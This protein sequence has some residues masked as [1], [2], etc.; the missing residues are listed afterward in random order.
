MNTIFTCYREWWKA[1][2]YFKRPVWHF[3]ITE[4]DRYWGTWFGI[5]PLAW[6][7][8]YDEARFE[9]APEIFIKVGKERFFVWKLQAP[10]KSFHY[11]YPDDDHY[12]EA[13]LTYLYN[14]FDRKDRKY[15]RDISKTYNE[16]VWSRLVYSDEDTKNKKYDNPVM[17]EVEYIDRAL[18]DYAKKELVKNGIKLHEN[19]LEQIMI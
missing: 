15:K 12:W 4:T 17:K 1:R 11:D 10:Y 6:K 16:Y 2:K 18:T 14:H 9:E 8:K 7:M 13:L 5:I 19:G 3:Y